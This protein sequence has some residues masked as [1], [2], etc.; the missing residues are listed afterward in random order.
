MFGC[1]YLAG[2][3]VLESYNDSHSMGQKE[4]YWKLGDNCLL[5]GVEI[6]WCFAMMLIIISAMHPVC[7]WKKIAYFH[8]LPFLMVIICNFQ[9]QRYK[10]ISIKVLK[11]AVLSVSVLAAQPWTLKK[12][13]FQINRKSKIWRMHVIDIVITGRYK[14]VLLCNYSGTWKQFKS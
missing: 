4:I 6:S 7:L 5:W 8:Y 3:S 10:G 2:Y 14:I 1:I 12:W 13:T 9:M 11:C